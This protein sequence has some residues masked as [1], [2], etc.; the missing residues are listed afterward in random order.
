MRAKEM[1]AT[2]TINHYERIDALS[3][4]SK[5]QFLN[6]LDAVFRKWEIDGGLTL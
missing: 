4:E 2:I 5:M 3:L 6:E 1:K